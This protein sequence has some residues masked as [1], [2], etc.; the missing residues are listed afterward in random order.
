MKNILIKGVVTFFTGIL[1]VTG[2]TGDFDE[3]NTDPDAYPYVPHTNVLGDMIRRTATQHGGDIGGY[4]TWAGYIAKVQYLDYMGGII[5]SDNTYGNRWT[6]CYVANWQLKNILD[7]TETDIEGNKNMRFACRIWQ[8]YLWSYLLDGWGDIPYSEAL[9]GAEED[10]QILFTKYDKQEEVYPQVMNSLK[11]IAD[12]M[13]AGL[14]SDDLG[15]G[16]FLFNGDVEKWQ[17]LCNSLRLRMAMRIVNVMP[18]LAK[19]TIEEICG[20]P[21]KYPF[22]NLNANAAD[23]WWQ[24]S[25][26][27][28]ERW[29]ND[30]RTRDDFGVSDIFIDHLKDMQDPRLSSIAKPAETDGEYRGV[31]NGPASVADI[32]A[33]S[34]IGVMYREDPD[35]FTPFFQACESYFII[36]EAAV[37]GWNVGMTAEEAYEKAVR[38]SMAVNEVS[39]ADADTYLAGKGK[40]NNTRE[41]IWWEMWVGLFKNNFEAWALYRRTGVP[42]TNYP[43][44]ESVWKGI[45]NDQ[46]FRLPYPNNQYLFNTEMVNAAVSSQGTV[47]Y[48]WGKQLFWDTRTGVN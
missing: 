26:E 10:G 17:R 38:L 14:G 23:F 22:I 12:E 31:Q 5:P 15:E 2:C 43:A 45:H 39:N 48:C 36:A 29:Y 32:K 35:G 11:A 3:I 18:D 47:D 27:Y 34:R 7:L 42:T 9:K 40:W 4:G 46:P 41:Q 13:A 6:N 16:D 21:S 30:F 8:N 20:S 24:G 28:F 33:I 44:I 25:G 1:L 19:S 37:L